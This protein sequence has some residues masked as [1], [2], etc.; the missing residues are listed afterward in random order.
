MGNIEAP[1]VSDPDAPIIKKLCENRGDPT[2]TAI[3]FKCGKYYQKF[4]PTSALDLPSNLYD[5]EGVNVGN[6]GGNRNPDMP[7]SKGC[8]VSCDK[9]NLCLKLK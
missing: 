5:E 4:P 3:L 1:V 8:E 9:Q 6:C 2:E 7:N